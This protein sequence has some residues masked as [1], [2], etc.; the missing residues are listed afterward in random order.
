MNKHATFTTIIDFSAHS[1][2]LKHKEHKSNW[3]A[4]GQTL[5]LLTDAPQKDGFSKTATDFRAV[6]IL[7]MGPCG[8]QTKVDIQLK[9]KCN[10][11]LDSSAVSTI[12]TP[13]NGPKGKSF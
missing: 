11:N 1:S 8:R 2:A 12:S 7:K 3:H 6:M 10:L 5:V 4:G 9:A 13:V